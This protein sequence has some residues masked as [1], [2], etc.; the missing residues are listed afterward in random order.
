MDF[1]PVRDLLAGHEDE[2]LLAKDVSVKNQV[3]ID[4][5]TVNLDHFNEDQA[6][7]DCRSSSPSSDND[8]IFKIQLF[9]LDYLFQKD[10]TGASTKCFSVGKLEFVDVRAELEEQ[11]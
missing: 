11:W 8:T 7:E 10:P 9:D 1:I 4:R 6:D 2:V 5:I 3:M